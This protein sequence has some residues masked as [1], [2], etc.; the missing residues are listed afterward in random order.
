MAPPRPRQ[1]TL[2]GAFCTQ[3]EVPSTRSGVK[4][5]SN[6]KP[7]LKPVITAKRAPER[8][9]TDVLLS[10]KPPHFV[11][12]ASQQKNHE[13]CKY[14]LKDGVERLWLY[15]TGDEGGRSSI[16]HIAV[17]PAAVR[18]TPGTVPTEPFGIG[19][20]DFNAG[21]KVSK[22]GY[23]ILKLYELLV[24]VALSEMKSQWEMGGALMG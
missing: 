7:K 18:R 10:I 11:N 19:N 21:R 15:E 24:P 9:L 20:D 12:I 4:K 5:P 14:W 16:T 2:D 13:Y 6:T 8:V 17:V 23:P 3:H 22:Y 1:T